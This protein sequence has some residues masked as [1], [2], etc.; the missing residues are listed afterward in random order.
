[1]ER[2]AQLMAWWRGCSPEDSDMT[3]LRQLALVGVI[4]FSSGHPALSQ[5]GNCSQ[6]DNS[7]RP[8]CPG[9]LAFFERLQ[10]A[11]RKNN[12]QAVALMVSYP[13]LTNIGHKKTRLRD[14]RQL[15]SHF[16]EVF[17][18]NTRCAILGATKRDVWGN[19]RGFTIANGVVWFEGIIPPKEKAYTNGPGFWKKYPFKIITVNNEGHYPCKG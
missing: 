14:R 6:I 10:L 4:A 12:R 7:S 13:L 1:M 5:T 9:A 3:A 16:D 15:L 17:D 18:P 11:L 8:D 19:W 2:W